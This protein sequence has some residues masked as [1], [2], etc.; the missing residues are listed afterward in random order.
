MT[1]LLPA[2]L[3]VWV[4]WGSTYF[5]IRVT[6]GSM[7]PF[8][9]AC[10]RLTIAGIVLMAFARLRGVRMPTRAE[11]WSCLA[12]GALLFVGG[13]GSVVFA[14]Q[15]V[16]SSLVA[17]LVSAVPLWSAV[18]GLGWGSAVSVRQWV[19]IVLGIVGVVVL[20]LGGELSG[21]T[22]ATVLV[23]LGSAAW[24]FG[25]VLGHHRPMPPGAMA[26]GAQMLAGG[27][28]LG[29]LSLASGESYVGPVTTEAWLALLYLITFG[30]LVAFSAYGWLLRNATL[31]V[32]TSYAYVNPVVAVLLGLLLGGEH[33]DA[34]GWVGLAIVVAG[35]VLVTTGRAAR[36]P[37]HAATAEARRD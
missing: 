33:L 13:N 34:H 35:V 9:M 21:N 8:G 10:V 27:L 24:A 30:S 3:A 19:G 2:L 17:I 23:M 12:V 31:P 5:A 36:E 14:E 11:W 28:C 37:A 18:I 22:G 20:N 29:L 4:L 16:S 6:V 1:R 15:T 25:S 26:S 32:A 7:P